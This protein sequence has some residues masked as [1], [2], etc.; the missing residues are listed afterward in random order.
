MTLIKHSL[1][2]TMHIKWT[3]STLNM[4]DKRIDLP[5][6]VNVPAQPLPRQHSCKEGQLMLN[7][8]QTLVVCTSF[9]SDT[10]AMT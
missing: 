10:P 9:P 2:H 6:N 5:E 7:Q 4:N 3:G 1:W 8:W